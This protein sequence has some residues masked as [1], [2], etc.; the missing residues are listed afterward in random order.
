MSSLLSFAI[1][2]D[3]AAAE[4]SAVE[5]TLKLA[6]G[7]LRWCFFITPSA[8]SAA[9]D[10]VPGTSVRF[11]LGVPHMIVVSEVSAEIIGRVLRYLDESGELLSVSREFDPAG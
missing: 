6:D 5:V 3:L 9:G 10:F 8:L 1:A 4:L 11:H 7:T 2:D